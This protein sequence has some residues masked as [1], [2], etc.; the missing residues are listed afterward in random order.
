MVSEVAET[1]RVSS[2]SEISFVCLYP[3]D[4]PKDYIE[5]ISDAMKHIGIFDNV[6]V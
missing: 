4:N 3:E 5:S 6:T 2:S 1:I